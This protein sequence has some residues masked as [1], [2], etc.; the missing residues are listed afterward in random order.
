M[1]MSKVY[2]HEQGACKGC[3]VEHAA[4]RSTTI[5]IVWCRPRALMHLVHHLMSGDMKIPLETTLM[6]QSPRQMFSMQSTLC[7][8][9]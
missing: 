5:S 6:R 8:T 7:K 1:I 3:F 2:D 4:I 9:S